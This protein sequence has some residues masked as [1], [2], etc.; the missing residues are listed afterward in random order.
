MARRG[1]VRGPSHPC[2]GCNERYRRH[3]SVASVQLAR[4]LQEA[5]L[6]II[7]RSW[8]R[9]PPAPHTLTCRNIRFG[10]AGPACLPHGCG[11][12]GRDDSGRAFRRAPQ[13]S[14]EA[15]T[16]QARTGQARRGRAA[17]QP[18]QVSR[19][20]SRRR[21]PAAEQVDTAAVEFGEF[22]SRSVCQLVTS[23]GRPSRP[24][25]RLT[26]RPGKRHSR[27]CAAPQA[28]RVPGR[29]RA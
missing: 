19:P 1:P 13:A 29:H 6:L 4:R 27:P 2:K 18:D 12:G 11:H 17:P 25:L 24:A 3:G 20:R 14:P 9:A 5:I 8:V 10:L 16:G 15:L 7:R 26:Q 21:S 23:V 28:V 22:L